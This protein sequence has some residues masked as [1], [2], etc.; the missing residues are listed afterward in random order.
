MTDNQPITTEELA[1]LR[2][3]AMKLDSD[4]RVSFVLMVIA[5]IGMGTAR[6]L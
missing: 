3:Q 6:Y 2:E 5:L 1:A 4:S